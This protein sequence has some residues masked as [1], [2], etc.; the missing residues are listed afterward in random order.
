MA[1]TISLSGQ[2][3]NDEDHNGLLGWESQLA[4]MGGD[5]R[6]LALVVFDVPTIKVHTDD[7]SRMPIVRLRVIEPVGWFEDAPA[8]LKE[9]MTKLKTDR[10]GGDPLPGDPDDDEDQD[11][12][13]VAYV[14]GPDDD[15]A[16]GEKLKR[17]ALKAVAS[18]FAEQAAE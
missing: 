12:D 7:G 16:R 4:D 5:A 18:P 1:G 13:D 2:L 17:A 11:D 6:L 8:E 14:T 10:S 9:I 15:P 3:P